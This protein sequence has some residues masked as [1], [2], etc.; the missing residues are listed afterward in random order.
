MPWAPSLDRRLVSFDRDITAALLLEGSAAL[1]ATTGAS[2]T[3][4][5]YLI[6]VGVVIY[7]YLGGLIST[8]LSNYIQLVNPFRIK[9]VSAIPSDTTCLISTVVTFGMPPITM[10][11][12][13][14]LSSVPILGTPGKMRDLLQPAATANPALG[15]KDG[16]YVTMESG[17]GLL[18]AGVI[19]VSGFGSVFVDPSYG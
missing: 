5:N 7:T 8:F 9:K 10:F 14:A 4:M 19:L 6:P 13:M 12:V 2:T 17:Q 3:A 1:T 16:S 11:K 15:A 18:L